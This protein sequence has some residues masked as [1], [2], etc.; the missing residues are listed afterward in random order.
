MWVV[1]VKRWGYFPPFLE[2]SLSRKV[3]GYQGGTKER[4]VLLIEEPN[5]DQHRKFLLCF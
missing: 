5:L 2:L 1:R 4:K 3:E